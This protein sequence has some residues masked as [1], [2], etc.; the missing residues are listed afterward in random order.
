MGNSNFI[1]ISDFQYTDLTDAA[2]QIQNRVDKLFDISAVMKLN[3][4]DSITITDTLSL[5]KNRFTRVVNTINEHH[6]HL[7][8]MLEK[9]KDIHRKIED[10]ML[11]IQKIENELKELNQPIGRNVEDV[12]ERTAAYQVIFEN[13]Y[14]NVYLLFLKKL[15]S[16]E[17]QK[18]SKFPINS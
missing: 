6:S 11:L 10:S 4:L 14:D 8:K 12:Y 1:L 2:G 16:C 13:S 18:A 3:N 9:Y 15:K 5:L 7:G 17:N